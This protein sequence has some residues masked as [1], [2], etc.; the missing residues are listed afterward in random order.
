MANFLELCSG[1]GSSGNSFM[2]S[3]WNENV[4]PVD[5]RKNPLQ[6]KQ[7]VICIS[8]SDHIYFSSF[9]GW[10]YLLSSV[11]LLSS[12]PCLALPGFDLLL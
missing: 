2:L 12:S 10:W 7:N 5:P 3:T 1:S 11:K 4:V 8:H 9:S 6:T